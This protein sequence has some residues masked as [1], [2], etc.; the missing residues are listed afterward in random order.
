M[1]PFTA[2]LASKPKSKINNMILQG[3]DTASSVRA[4]RLKF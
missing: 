4:R 3:M 2:Q 1:G